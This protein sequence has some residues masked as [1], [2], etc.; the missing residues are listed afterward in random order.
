L[1]RQQLNLF[2]KI[3]NDSLSSSSTKKVLILFA[4]N[5]YQL[6]RFGQSIGTVLS[7]SLINYFFGFSLNPFEN[8]KMSLFFEGN[9]ANDLEFIDK[10]T[11]SHLYSSSSFSSNNSSSSLD[12]HALSESA[13]K[14]V[15]QLL[16][17][18]FK[19][20]ILLNLISEMKITSISSLQEFTCQ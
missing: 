4:I 20:M 11:F 12:N 19:V 3:L 9:S 16:Q 6:M 15:N 1:L 14:K 10:F 17:E 18:L 2:Q 5:Q 7:G 13:A 8:N